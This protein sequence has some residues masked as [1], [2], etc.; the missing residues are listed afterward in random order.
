M[1]YMQTFAVE[2]GTQASV[3]TLW[4]KKGSYIERRRVPWQ[5]VLARLE[6]QQGP[7]VAAACRR[8]IK[9]LLKNSVENVEN[10]ILSMLEPVGE[11]AGPAVLAFLAGEPGEEE[12]GEEAGLRSLDS[13]LLFLRPLLV[14][15]NTARVVSVLW[16]VA[17]R[18]ALHCTAL[19]YTALHCTAAPWRRP[20]SR[21][22]PASGRRPSSSRSTP[23]SGYL[24]SII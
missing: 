8:T 3:L 24:A 19:H 13:A 23:P 9:T 11:R 15:A 2:L 4:G 17:V 5:D 10:Q 12:A 22:S 6:A 16:A 14:P 21:G 18:S 7:L 1:S 20:C